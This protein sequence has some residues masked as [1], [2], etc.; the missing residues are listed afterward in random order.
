MMIPLQNDGFVFFRVQEDRYCIS[1]AVRY[2]KT[3]VRVGFNMQLVLTEGYA[4]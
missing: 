4:A 3:V 2:P 1:C